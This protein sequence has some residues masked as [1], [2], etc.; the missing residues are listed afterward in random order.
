MTA[1]RRLG[2][3]VAP[4]VPS[5]VDDGHGLSLRGRGGGPGGRPHAHRHRRHGN[6]QRRRDR[7]GRRAPGSTSI[8]TDHHRVPP[9][10]PPAVARSSTRTAPTPPTRTVASP[11]AG[12]ALKVA[13]LLL[14]DRRPGE[15]ARSLDLADLAA[16][17]TVADV[18]PSSARTGRSRGS[19]WSG[20][21]PAPRPG[22]AALLAAA[23]V[24][25]AAA[26]LE[27]IAFVIAP[28]L[29][30]AGR[31]GDAD[32]AAALLL[33]DDPAEA[34]AI[35][36]AALEGAN[37]AR[38]DVTQDGPRGGAGRCSPTE[39]ADLPG[40]AR[41]G[42][43][44]GRG[45]RAGGR[46]PCRGARPP[47]RRGDR[48]R[49]RPARLLPGAATG[50]DLAA[51]ARGAAPT[52]SSA[53]AATAARPA[54]RS[55]R[56]A[57]TRFRARFLE[58]VAPGAPRDP[59]PGARAR[60]RPPGARGVDYR[61][62]RELAALEPTGPGNPDPLVGVHGLTVTRVR[63]AAGGHAQLTLRRELDVVDAIAFERGD[64]V[65]ALRRGRPGRRRRPAR[66]AG[67]SAATSRSSSTSSTSRRPATGAE[68]RWPRSTPAIGRQS[69]ERAAPRRSCRLAAPDDRR[70]V[71]AGGRAARSSPRSSPSPASSSS[72][73]LTLALLTGNVP[74][75]R[76]GGSGSG[77]NGD[78][79]GGTACRRGRRRR[80]RRRS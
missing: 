63:A 49:G 73:L 50:Y 68:P 51:R 56:A 74:S 20:S 61:L 58:L 45:H 43:L 22:F 21:G 57:G 27:T 6:V 24:A 26:T 75:C 80:A 33:A 5:R 13:A 37:V 34:A 72:A 11:G 66:R 30:A 31:V 4:H 47:G 12:V 2:L 32:D 60:P 59:R 44:A 67:A 18:A 28:R 65:D 35:A 14:E 16:I 42:T 9:S 69:D 78:P 46:P 39:A 29:N 7:R 40:H 15:R 8:V 41:P 17:G 10:P 64:L 79:G 25:P 52:C 71:R 1:L 53:T 36:A 77:G 38:R 55:C 48:A 19:A 62:L 54:S 23:G 3:D 76:R 70:P